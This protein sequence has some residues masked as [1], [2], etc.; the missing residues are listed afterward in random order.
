M[1]QERQLELD[2]IGDGG[3]TEAGFLGGEGE[4]G[5]RGATRVTSAVGFEIC[6]MHVPVYSSTVC[7][8]PCRRALCTYS[9]PKALQLLG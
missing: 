3:T 5:G 4:E 8:L 1:L 6:T 7:T 9:V 2:S